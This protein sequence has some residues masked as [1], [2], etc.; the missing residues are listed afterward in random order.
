MKEK[1]ARQLFL[2]LWGVAVGE[3][4]ASGVEDWTRGATIG[5][6]DHHCE[7]FVSQILHI[8]A[9]WVLVL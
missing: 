7:V 6:S 9:T 5:C 3:G 2:L 1:E 8:E 4:R